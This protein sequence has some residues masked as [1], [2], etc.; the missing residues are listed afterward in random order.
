MAVLLFGESEDCALLEG[1]AIFPWALDL[2]IVPKEKNRLL[3]IL[4]FHSATESQTNRWST[5]SSS[6]SPSFNTP[7]ICHGNH[8]RKICHVE[9][10]HISVHDRCGEISN[11]STCG[12][13]SH[14]PHERCGEIWNF[15]TCGVISNVFTWQMWRGPGKFVS[16]TFSKYFY[17]YLV[18]FV[19]IIIKISI[20]IIIAII[21]I[22]IS[23][24]IWWFLS[25]LS[26][27]LPSWL[28]LQSS[29]S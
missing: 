1:S 20:I 22:I 23:M 5:S 12:L 24:F 13:I 9:K 2:P 6:F 10:F 19:I 7:D 15:S 3:S 14:S 4:H 8:E 25:S 16:K 26:S 21:V 17:V 29:L 18:I 11:F 27:K 28:S